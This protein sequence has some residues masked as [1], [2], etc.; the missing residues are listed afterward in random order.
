MPVVYKTYK[1]KCVIQEDIVKEPELIGKNLHLAIDSGCWYFIF[2]SC[3]PW[4]HPTKKGKNNQDVEETDEEFKKRQDAFKWKREY[5]GE[6]VSKKMSL[7]EIAQL[8]ADDEE[9]YFFL[10]SRLCHGY[11]RYQTD[12][13]PVSLNYSERVANLQKLKAWFKYDKNICDILIVKEN[14]YCPVCNQQHMDISNIGNWI[15]NN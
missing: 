7:N 14:E 4:F 5:F 13:K 2:K 15:I 6:A 1:T 12:E 10:I 3:P 8:M 11:D 9:K